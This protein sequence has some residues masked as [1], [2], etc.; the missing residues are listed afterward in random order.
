[1]KARTVYDELNFQNELL[2]VD[3]V[4]LSQLVTVGQLYQENMELVSEA[5]EFIR[6]NHSDRKNNLFLKAIISHLSNDEKPVS[7]TVYLE[8]SKLKVK[9]VGDKLSL[10]FD[11]L[12]SESKFSEV[13][14]ALKT[15]NA[16]K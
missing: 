1:M 6:A 4:K 2:D 8:G 13:F 15:M 14:E 7:K 9:R 5:V 3:K 12:P 16:L 11:G 10:S